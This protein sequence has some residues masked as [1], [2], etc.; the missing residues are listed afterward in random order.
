MK[1]SVVTFTRADQ[2]RLM[3]FLA[4][5]QEIA[6]ELVVLI[7]SEAKDSLAIAQRFTNQVYVLPHKG[8]I[9][10]HLQE[11]VSHC[12][13]DW[14][15]RIDDDETLSPQW[16]R[17]L[18]KELMSDRYTTHYWIPR[19]WLVSSGAQFI[20]T[21]PWYPDYQ[22]RLFRNIPSLIKLPNKIHEATQVAGGFRYLTDAYL[23]H[24]DLVWNNR[25]IR[26]RK[27]A[28]YKE[29]N[30]ENSGFQYYLYEN[31]YY[32]TACVEDNPP[33]A[34]SKRAFES[35]EIDDVN[36]SFKA[37][38]SILDAPKRM[39]ANQ[40]YVVSISIK[41]L[42]DHVLFS[43]NNLI[44]FGNTFLAYHWF[45]PDVFEVHVWDSPR[46]PLPSRI[47]PGEQVKSFLPVKAPSEKGTYFLQPDIVEEG[48]AWFSQA[49]S[50]ELY[51]VQEIETIETETYT[52]QPSNLQQAIL[53]ETASADDSTNVHPD[54]LYVE[55]VYSEWVDMYANCASLVVS[56]LRLAFP[57]ETVVDVGCGPCIFANEFAKQG[58]KVAATDGSKYAE[59]YVSKDVHYLQL[60]FRVDGF[61][62]QLKSFYSVYDIA[63]CMEVAE[64]L[65][66]E[67]ASS[68][69]K[70]LTNLSSTIA[71]TAAQPGQGGLGH[72]NE[73][74][75]E[76]WQALFDRFGYSL[77]E[78]YTEAL[79]TLWRS[80]NVVWWLSDNLLI[81][82]RQPSKT[83]SRKIQ[84]RFKEF[85][86]HFSLR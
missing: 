50:R 5:L 81:F 18:I 60:D 53:S 11:V 47:A 38:I 69:V 43:G 23:Y 83:V 40:T 15:F 44:D 35:D 86:R 58:S 51:E 42:S 56:S 30:P 3:K 79:R 12:S 9:E 14:I 73:Q 72:F 75:H 19:L 70:S 74:P 17:T 10:A 67:N 63:L 24:W 27:V 7:D 71:F 25:E 54:E 64:H 78:K 36:S 31:F 4:S 84:G 34:T 46:F 22:M 76:Y 77:D 13:G 61:E 57:I 66:P 33:D 45:H 55:S 6:D 8:Y 59:E 52:L 80:G 32:E 41:N 16:T 29:L 62:E 68:L 1:L 85:L 82:R 26:E 65:P 28:R 2:D 49:S 21:A 37:S 20:K 39:V 48:V